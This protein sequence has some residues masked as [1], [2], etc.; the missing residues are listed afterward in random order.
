METN[1]RWPNVLAERLAR[2]GGP[3]VAV[4]NQGISGAKVLVDRMGVNALARFERDVLAQPHVDTVIVMIGI[5][6]IGW[7]GAKLLSPNDPPASLE[8]TI[9]GDRHPI[10]R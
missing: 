5:N 8:P 6:D 1:G 4:L 10:A 3:P 2:A 9:A 7:P